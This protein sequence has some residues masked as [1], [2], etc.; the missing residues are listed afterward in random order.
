M[1]IYLYFALLG[2]YFFLIPYASADNMSDMM[3]Y[4]VIFGLPIIFWLWLNI[5]LRKIMKHER[6]YIVAVLVSMIPGF[7]PGAIWGLGIWGMAHGDD[8]FSFLAYILI[9]GIPTAFVFVIIGLL[10][11]FILDKLYST[12]THQNKPKLHGGY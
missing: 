8:V 9:C 4:S 11:Q 3:F 12:G 6:S 7:F 1:P 10:F 2:G 5:R